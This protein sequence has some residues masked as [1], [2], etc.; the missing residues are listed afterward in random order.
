LF[1]PLLAL[2][3]GGILYGMMARKHNW[4][5]YQGI[6]YS[7]VLYVLVM[8]VLAI[9]SK[10]NVGLSEEETFGEFMLNVTMNYSVLDMMITAS[11]LS[12][13]GFGFAATVTYFNK[14]ILEKLSYQV[15][16]VQYAIFSIAIT[17]VGIVFNFLNVYFG[18]DKKSFPQ[19]MP[20]EITGTVKL[21][22]SI[23]LG[24]WNW[25]SSFFSELELA[26]KEYGSNARYTHSLFGSEK[27]ELYNSYLFNNWFGQSDL[28]LLP[29]FLLVLVSVGLIGAA[30]YILYIVHRLN[31]KECLTFAGIFTL[32]QLMLLYLINVQVDGIF[33]YGEVALT[34]SFKVISSCLLVFVVAFVS[35]YVGGFVR[36]YQLKK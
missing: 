30:G 14:G 19:D 24:V 17:I 22:S 7:T 8:I 12:I 20:I 3:I 13:V 26:L 2:V 32:L 33:D 25:I 11:I 34:L 18:M 29:S 31:W 15:K 28:S 21:F 16:Y 5:L 10:L 27:S 23:Y 35:F 9:V 1:L 6:A 4:P 36:Q